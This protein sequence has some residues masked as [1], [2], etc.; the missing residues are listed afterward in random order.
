MPGLFT[1]MFFKECPQSPASGMRREDAY[2]TSRRDVLD[3]VP[4]NAR[5]ILDVGCSNGALGASLRAVSPGCR[6]TGI[7]LNPE[8]VR[9]AR[10]R[11]DRVVHADLNCF[12]WDVLA[13]EEQFDCIIFA[14]V[15]EHLV[16]PVRHIVGARRCL[17]P[18]G[19][20]VISLPNIR[21]VSS[22]Y[23]IFLRGTFPKRDRGIFDATHLHWFTLRDARR[24]VAESGLTI[25][26]ASYG[27]RV[28]D[29]AGGFL[30]RAAC[31]VLDP[32]A[33]FGPIREFLTYQFC[34]RVVASPSG[35]VI[36]S[37]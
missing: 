17:R 7:E 5:S 30:N 24:L 33:E 28:R 18:G 8:F 6:V 26:A 23:S 1:N 15:L 37:R 36:S 32:I 3:M 29:Q 35:R 21:H 11:L 12:D 25:E 31:K 19:A 22:F 2:T 4:T 13:S 10:A 27:L 9:R 16:D 20:M 34:L 14:D